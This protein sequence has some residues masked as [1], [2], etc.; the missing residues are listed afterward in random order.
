MINMDGKGCVVWDMYLEENYWYIVELVSDFYNRY[1]VDL[2]LSEKF[3]VNG[4][5]ILIVWLCI[6]LNGYGEVNFKGVEYYYKLFVECYKCYVEL[7]VILYYFDILEVL[8]KD[9]DFLNCKMIDYFVDYVEYCFKEFL[10]V[11]YWIIFNEIG[12]IGDG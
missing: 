8:Y 1:L 12:F 5:C 2:E 3:G 9:G 6:F 7:F 4:I 10:E 11:K